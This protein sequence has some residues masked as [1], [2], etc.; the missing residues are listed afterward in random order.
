MLLFLT[1]VVMTP[2]LRPKVNDKKFA[3]YL[4][5][6]PQQ[7]ELTGGARRETKVRDRFLCFLW[8]ILY[9]L[10]F[11]SADESFFKWLD[12]SSILVSKDKYPFLWQADSSGS[13]KRSV[14]I[15][16]DGDQHGCFGFS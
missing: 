15:L 9:E 5:N 11:A 2:L 10:S 13:L 6:L 12:S 3:L 16:W 7:V 1:Y 4:A 8:C 14:Q